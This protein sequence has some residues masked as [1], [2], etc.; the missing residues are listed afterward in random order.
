MQFLLSYKLKS[1][2]ERLRYLARNRNTYNEHI[3]QKIKSENLQYNLSLILSHIIL[4]LQ[5]I[6]RSKKAFE[7]II[8]EY[9]NSNKTTLAFEDFEKIGWIR[10]VTN[11]VLIPELVRHFIWQVSYYEKKGESI[12]IP[13]DKKD[14]TA[15]L[16][17]YSQRCF[18][19]AKLTIARVELETILSNYAPKEVSIDFLIEKEIIG[20]YSETEV[21]Y[22]KDHEYSRHLRNEIASTIWLLIGGEESTIIEFKKYFKLIQGTQLWIEDLRDYLTPKN[23]SKISDLAALFLSSEIDLLKSNDEFSKIWLDAQRYQHIDIKTDIPVVE[24]NYNNA[25]EFIES[26]NYHKWRYRDLFDYQQTRSHCYLLLKIIVH[27]EPIYS[28]PYQNT[29]KILKDTSR[30]FLLWVLYREIPDNFPFVIPYLLTDYE[31]IPIALQLIDKIKIDD[32][33]LSEQ[34]NNDRKE[35]KT[36][37]LK[38]QLWIEMFDLTLEQF[39]STYSDDKEKGETIA[40]VL[41][42]SAEKAFD[43]IINNTNNHIRHNALRRRYEEALKK[44]SYQRVK[45]TNIYPT[46]LINKRIA[47]FLLP[48]IAKYLNGKLSS[49]YPNHT[50]LLYLESALTDLSIETLRLSNIGF[51][52]DEISNKQKQNIEE[53]II[54]LVSSLESYLSKF[55]SQTDVDVQTYTALGTEKRTIKRGTNEFG[56]EIID[57]GY[58]FLNFEKHSILEAFHNKFTT[59]LNFNTNGDKYDEQNKNQFEKINLYLKS[60]MVGFISTHQ[61]KDLY[62]IDRLPVKNTLFFLEKWIRDFSLFYSINDLNNKRIDV[63]NEMFNVFGYGIYHQ[64]LTSLLYKSINY[65]TEK[66][67]NE[68]VRDFF[69]TSNDIGRMLTAINILD[70]KEQ[71]NIISQRIS[72]IEIDEFIENSFN[73]TELQYA[74]IEA[75]NSESHWELAKPLVKRIQDHFKQV[76]YHDYYQDSLLFQVNLLLIIKEKDFSKLNEIPIPT[77]SYIHAE[78]NEKMEKMKQFYIAL[79]V[80]YNDRNYD[81][82]I[83]LLKPLLSEDSKNIKYAFHLY[84]AETLK[85]INNNMESYV[86]NQAN[87]DWEIFVNSLTNKEKENLSEL[88][89]LISINRL[90]YYASINDVLRFDQTINILSKKYLH[91]EEIIPTAYKSYTERDLHELA[92]DYIQKSHDYLI[93]NNTDISPDIQNIFNNAESVKLLQKYKISLERIRNLSPSKIPSITPDTVNNKRELNDFILNELIQSLRIIREKKEALKQVT[94]ENRYN[95]FLEAILRFRFPVWGWSIHDQSRLGTSTGGADAGNADLV[96]Q[97]G[98]GTNIALIEPFILK[99]KQYTETHILKCPNYIGTINKY[100]III[101]YMGN[102]NNFERKWDE[103]KSDVLSISYP[104]NF[105]IDSTIG[106]TDMEN[107]FEDIV[108]IKIANTIH[109]TNL[110]MFHVMINLGRS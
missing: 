56:F 15:C 72:E 41:I 90:H 98:G 80:L 9:N 44:L 8:E 71:Q 55:Y 18:E 3:D 86:L 43:Y 1:L 30:P 61:K 40:K 102:P 2:S 110:K 7:D 99:D 105:S 87:Q 34:S 89:E 78:F 75:V 62:E 81:E 57:W 45:N 5:F 82:S 88:T 11:E 13:I 51:S 52:E 79:F 96:I 84:R 107:E 100:Y 68:F 39:S 91:A 85:A 101:Y 50:D 20:T 33:L 49:P 42:D 65:F 25:F 76:K 21:Y 104:I 108:N 70:L 24:F 19:N 103:Y 74:L 92:F 48:H 60:L 97:S 77:K 53:C 59:S 17:V 35:E 63:F 12:E 37:E 47:F 106:F 69:A 95:D 29:L 94:H 64:H 14:I 109:N 73:T 38:N 31:L 46:S 10:N 22:W 28:N 83:K 67:S 27:N 93:K 36:C 58:L 4:K 16:Q 54:E 23:T 6:D 32:V 26:V 66:N